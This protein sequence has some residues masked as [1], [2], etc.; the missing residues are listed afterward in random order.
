MRPFPGQQY[1]LFSA[2][3]F[4]Y[5]QYTLKKKFTKEDR[6]RGQ[7]KEKKSKKEVKKGL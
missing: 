5:K 2:S 4:S 1:L 7:L 6:F 3:K